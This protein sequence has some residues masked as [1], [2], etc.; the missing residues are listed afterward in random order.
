MQTRQQE[1][2][3]GRVL[4]GP[5][6]GPGGQVAGFWEEGALQGDVTGGE[7]SPGRGKEVHPRRGKGRE[8]DEV[9]DKGVTKRNKCVTKEKSCWG[10]PL[11]HRK[12]SDDGL[13]RDWT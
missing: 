1:A 8:V 12:H 5:P 2:G 7:I 11:G 3:R 4:G 10:R 6:G 9:G 13:R